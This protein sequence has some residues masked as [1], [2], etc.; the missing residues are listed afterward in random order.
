MVDTNIPR[1]LDLV[2]QIRALERRLRILEQSTRVIS[3]VNDTGQFIFYAADGVTPIMQLGDQ[4]NGDRGILLARETGPEAL[5]ISKLFPTDANQTLQI[6]D[7]SG[8]VVIQDEWFTGVGLNWP[9]LPI[10]FYPT[11]TQLDSTT[12]SAVFVDLLRARIRRLNPGFKIYVSVFTSGPGVQA[13]I[14][15]WDSFFGPIAGTLQTHVLGTTA[16]AYTWTQIVPFGAWNDERDMTVQGR[17]SA[18]GPGTL[19]MRVVSVIGD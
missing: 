17:I 15:L 10:H 7:R 19:T 14:Q 12:T 16:T 4:P 13:E 5:R 2:G 9:K 1:Q 6:S 11:G 3:L 8:N 18:G